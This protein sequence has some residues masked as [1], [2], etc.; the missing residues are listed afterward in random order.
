[1]R[2]IIWRLRQR[3]EDGVAGVLV[4]LIMLVLIGAGAM[5]V[6]VGQ[7]YSERAQLQNAADAGALAVADSCSKGTCVVGL[8]APLADANS[9]D[10]KSEVITPVDLSVAGQVTVRT[11]T[12]NGAGT[13]STLSKLF[14]SAL[15]SAPAATVGATAT[16]IW[17]KT[18]PSGAFPLV[19]DQCQVG[20]TYAPL[21]TTV[22]IKEHGKSPCVGSPSGHHIPGGFGWL[23]PDPILPCNANTDSNGWVGSNPGNSKTPSDCTSLLDAWRATI[24]NSMKQYAIGYFPLFDDGAGNGANGSFHIVG[25]AKVEIHGWSFVQ[26]DDGLTGSKAD[27]ACVALFKKGSDRGICGQFLKFIPWSDRASV[28]GPLFQQT[29]VKLIK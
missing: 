24:D 27:P 1:M 3:G 29:V 6:D 18:P 4:V 5:A 7:I 26:D 23:D 12:R 28:D 9:L 15:S 8:A 16:A 21:G 19:F 25:Y 22:L 17:Q 13:S 14:A 11:K 2:R 20:S 10:G